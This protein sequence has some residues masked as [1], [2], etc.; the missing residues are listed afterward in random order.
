[1]LLDTRL[2]AAKKWRQRKGD[3]GRYNSGQQQPREK[4][5]QLPDP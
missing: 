4:R 1:M 2:H 5:M 3:R